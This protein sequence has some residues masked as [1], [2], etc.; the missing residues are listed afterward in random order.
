MLKAS[1]ASTTDQLGRSLLSAPLEDFGDL[2]MEHHDDA[3]TRRLLAV[4]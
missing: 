1:P 2:L 4:R 3:M